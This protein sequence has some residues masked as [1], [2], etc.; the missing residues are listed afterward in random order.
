MKDWVILKL[1]NRVRNI[2]HLW[3]GA[4]SSDAPTGE[5]SLAWDFAFFRLGKKY[6]RR[7]VTIYHHHSVLESCE[8]KKKTQVLGLLFSCFLFLI[9]FVQQQLYFLFHP[10]TNHKSI[11]QD[12]VQ[13]NTVG[14][15]M[16]DL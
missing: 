11:H 15:M 9:F 8:V 1:Q 10:P 5:E 7:Q 6:I 16:R 4:I 13:G 12:G 14:L 3:S 2:P